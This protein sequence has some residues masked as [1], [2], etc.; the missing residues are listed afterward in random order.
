MNDDN[1]EWLG[2]VILLGFVT[3][4]LASYLLNAL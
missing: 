4:I 1:G 3:L 2:L